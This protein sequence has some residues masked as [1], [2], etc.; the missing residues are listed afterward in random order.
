MGTS[1]NSK[2]D[3]RRADRRKRDHK[4]ADKDRKRPETVKIRRRR[5]R[6]TGGFQA[7][8]EKSRQKERRPRRRRK[9]QKTVKKGGFLFFGT[10]ILGVFLSLEGVQSG[11]IKS[12]TLG[13][14]RQ[15]GKEPS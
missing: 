1:T 11:T 2:K 14:L 6:T 8:G 3:E 7:Y 9:R 12:G 13:G 15:T 10:L 4:D 5:V